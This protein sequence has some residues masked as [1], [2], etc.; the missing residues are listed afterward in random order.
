MYEPQNNKP[1][2]SDP[3][4]EGIKT[5]P[6][7]GSIYAMHILEQEGTIR[8]VRFEEYLATKGITEVPG[9]VLEAC[10]VAF[11]GKVFVVDGGETLGLLHIIKE[12]GLKSKQIEKL[13]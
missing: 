10:E 6:I 8:L 11:G 12:E 5:S 7:E 1:E 9:D 3:K 4:I 2:N 13:Y